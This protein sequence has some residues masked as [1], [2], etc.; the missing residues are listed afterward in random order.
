MTIKLLLFEEVIVDYMNQDEYILYCQNAIRCYFVDRY[1]H[2]MEY[3]KLRVQHRIGYI[4]DHLKLDRRFAK[5]HL[6]SLYGMIAYR[7]GL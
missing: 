7:K 2:S 1:L 5:L 6:S 3:E 4:E